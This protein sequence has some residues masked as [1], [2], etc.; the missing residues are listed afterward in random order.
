M[1]PAVGGRLTFGLRR[2][3]R[4]T[5]AGEGEGE[6]VQNDERVSH[7]IGSPSPAR[8]SGSPPAAASGAGRR[9]RAWALSWH[10]LPAHDP[11]VGN[12]GGSPVPRKTRGASTSEEVPHHR[13]GEALGGGALEQRLRIAQDS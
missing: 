10:G 8:C 6:E 3:V 7:A 2:V 13:G 4:R 5:A 12:T 11:R 1:S 9:G